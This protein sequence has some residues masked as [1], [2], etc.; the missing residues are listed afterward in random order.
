[1]SIRDQGPGIS[2]GIIDQ[3][4]STN[5]RL[6]ISKVEGNGMGLAIVKRICDISGWLLSINTSS[7]GSIFTI[8]FPKFK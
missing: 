6:E 2:Q 8:Q 7:Q 4:F 1:L 3:I 5:A